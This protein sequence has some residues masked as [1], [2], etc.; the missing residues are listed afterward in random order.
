M[1]NLVIG[2][3]SL[4]RLSDREIRALFESAEALGVREIDTAPSYGSSEERI[5]KK[6]T[7]SKIKINSL[8]ALLCAI[9][10]EG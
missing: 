10:D 2:G 7:S 8:K 1:S 6:L 5:G 4:S 9:L 3:V